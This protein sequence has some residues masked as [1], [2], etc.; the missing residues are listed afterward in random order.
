MGSLYLLGKYLS[1]VSSPVHLFVGCFVY[2]FL[3][4]AGITHAR[5]VLWLLIL[6]N[7]LFVTSSFCLS[8]L[9]TTIVKKHGYLLLFL[10]LNNRV[11]QGVP[12]PQVLRQGQG[13][14]L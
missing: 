9:I 3:S 12:L 6:N 11:F 14:M 7:F 1:C 5:Q 10:P 2:I 4:S 13:S 8:A